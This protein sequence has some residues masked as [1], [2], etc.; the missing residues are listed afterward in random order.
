[1][2]IL[3]SAFGTTGTA[4]APFDL[5]RTATHEIGHWL[6]LRHI[7]GDDGTGCSGD[8]FVADT[9]NAGGPNFGAPT[10][11]HVSCNNGPNG[12][13]FMNYMDYVDDVAMFMFT[14]GQVDR[15]QAALDGPRSSIGVTGPCGGKPIKEIVQGHHQ[16][17]RQR[18]AQGSPQGPVKEQPKDF[19]KEPIKDS[20]KDFVKEPIKEQPKDLTKDFVKEQ[21][22]DLGSTYP[23]ALL[24]PPKGFRSD[25]P[26]PD[27][28]PIFG[29]GLGRSASRAHAVRARRSRTPVRDAVPLRTAGS[30]AADPLVA[31]V[32]QLG[33][34]LAGVL[35]SGRRGQLDAGATRWQQLSTIY[36]QLVSAR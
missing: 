6:N 11:P 31:V 8:D 14:A 26:I 18:P 17:S 30:P 7:W 5:G 24:D 21:P 23:R 20:P 28:G 32:Q 10:F 3:H 25:V 33:G 9:P 2:V 15:M 4:A 22:K 16:G 27:P 13:L 12:D 29:W 36:A 35:R 34:L 1:M 19:V